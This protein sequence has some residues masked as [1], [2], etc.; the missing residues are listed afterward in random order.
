[1]DPDKLDRWAAQH[2]GTVRIGTFDDGSAVA[3]FVTA[4]GAIPTTGCSGASADFARAKLLR[5]LR[6]A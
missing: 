6:A 4:S 5:S 3:V 2:G 1:M